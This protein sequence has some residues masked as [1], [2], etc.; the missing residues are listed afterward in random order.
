MPREQG[1]VPEDHPDWAS[2]AAFRW[3]QEGEEGEGQQVDGNGIA[4][5]AEPVAAPGTLGVPLSHPFQ[6]Q[7]CRV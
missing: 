4:S 6:L 3:G 7:A 5:T 1:N 2:G